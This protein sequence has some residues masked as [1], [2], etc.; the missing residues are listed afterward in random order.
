MIHTYKRGDKVLV[1]V[2]CIIFGFDQSEEELL[3][4]VK[5]PIEPKLGQWSLMG[6]LLRLEETLN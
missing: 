5:I 3:L 2:G 6:G 1:A 4:L